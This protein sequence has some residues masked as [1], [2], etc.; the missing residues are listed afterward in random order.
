M[1]FYVDHTVQFEFALITRYILN[2][3]IVR[4]NLKYIVHNK[5]CLTD[6]CHEAKEDVI[7]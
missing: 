7:K 1:H 3:L 4:Y 5:I 6:T 2:S